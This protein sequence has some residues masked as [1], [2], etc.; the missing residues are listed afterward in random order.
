MHSPGPRSWESASWT[1]PHTHGR[2]HE[3]DSQLRGPG[4]CIDLVHLPRLMALR[5]RRAVREHDLDAV[6]QVVTA[7]D[8]ALQR[9]GNELL[10]Q[11]LVRLA[12]DPVTADEDAV[13]EHRG[14]DLLHRDHVEI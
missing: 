5:E 3:A 13:F 11:R 10:R 4:E 1:R 14:A 12:L 8:P 9:G 6:A 7:P 2:V